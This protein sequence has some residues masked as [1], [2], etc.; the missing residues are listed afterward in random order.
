MPSA[1]IGVWSNV[2]AIDFVVGDEALHP[3]DLWTHV[4][5]DAARF[6]SDG[7]KFR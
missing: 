7:L 6:L 3:L 5:K 4:A 1:A 2:H